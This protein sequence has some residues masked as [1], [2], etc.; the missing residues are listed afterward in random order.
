MLTFLQLRLDALR[1]SGSR[2][3]WWTHGLYNLALTSYDKHHTNANNET[4]VMMI[5]GDNNS[6]NEFA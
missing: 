6:S 4:N 2:R 1:Q 5:H 3:H